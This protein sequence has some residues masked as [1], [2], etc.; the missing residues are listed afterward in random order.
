MKMS[1]LQF[2]IT[3]PDKKQKNLIIYQGK[4]KIILELLEKNILRKWL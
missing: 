1:R 2:K 3:Q 4:D